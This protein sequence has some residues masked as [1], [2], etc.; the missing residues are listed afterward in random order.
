MNNTHISS[1]FWFH[2]TINTW[3]IMR[4]MNLERFTH[5]ANLRSLFYMSPTFSMQDV[6]L[7]AVRLAFGLESFH[8]NSSQVNISHMFRRFLWHPSFPGPVWIKPSPVWTV[9]PGAKMPH[10]WSRPSHDHA[11]LQIWGFERAGK[12]WRWFEEAGPH[13]VD[14]HPEPMLLMNKFLLTSYPKL[15]SVL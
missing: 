13:M 6:L 11:H 3:E 10:P 2:I 7:A 4:K 8:T 1:R 9:C 12:W 5:L 15:I 14:W